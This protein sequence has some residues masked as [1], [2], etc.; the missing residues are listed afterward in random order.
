MDSLNNI[1]LL[2]GTPYRVYVNAQMSPIAGTRLHP[3]QSPQLV[4]FI[5]AGNDELH[6]YS[7]DDDRVLRALNAYFFQHGILVEQGQQNQQP[8]RIS[9]KRSTMKKEEEENV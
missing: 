1:F 2:A 7:E 3:L 9:K 8:A 4:S 6:V 5:V